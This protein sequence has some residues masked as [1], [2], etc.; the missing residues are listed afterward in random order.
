VVLIVTLAFPPDPL[1]GAAR[2]G[3]FAR[4]LTQF[5]YEPIVIC[6][7]APGQ[8]ADSAAVR[9]VPLPAPS[10]AVRALAGLGHLAQRFLLPYNDSVPWAAHALVEAEAVLAERPVAAILSTSPPVGCHLVALEL[11]RRYGL[12]WV[13]DFRDPLWGNPFR[14]RR[15]IFPY[16]AMVERL[17]FRHADALIANTDTVAE[18]WLHRHRNVAHKVTVIW[19][20]Y[21]P[22]DRIEALS[23]TPADRRVLAHVGSIYGSRHPSRLFASLVRLIQAGKLVAD[24][25]G[26]RLVGP[27]DEDCLRVNRKAV[28]ALRSWNCLE[29][30]GKQ[31]PQAEARQAVAR[32]DY[33]LLLDLNEQD[34]DL[35]V[36]A[37]V[38]EYVQ[39]GRPIL[40]FTRRDSPTD[41]ILRGSGVPY[42]AVYH[43]SSDAEADCEV[44]GLFDLSTDPVQPSVWFIE[45]FDGRNQ[46]R[47]LAE[48]LDAVRFQSRKETGF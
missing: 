14:T 13:A 12:P 4:Y 20:G 18:F 26:V 36:P 47:K 24:R 37:K 41:R 10:R 44:S 40:A 8:T 27:I 19:N 45:Q 2:P 34:A 6:Q 42:R 29:Y 16:D 11:K 21:D 23:S 35:Q 15:W 28:D 39:I 32:A 46:T 22:E 25:I 48:I 17:L 1:S 9:R 30:D 3:R 31:V 43:D 33:L 7:N 5:G 38:F